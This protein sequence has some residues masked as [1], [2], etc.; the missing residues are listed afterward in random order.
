MIDKK[1]P[2]IKLAVLGHPIKH[3]LSPQIHQYFAKQHARSIDYQKIDID[4]ELAFNEF[5]QQASHEFIGCNVTIPYKQSLLTYAKQN[6][7]TCTVS[8]IAYQAKAANTIAF[9]QPKPNQHSITNTDGQGFLNHLS[10]LG[11]DMTHQRI[12]II[13]AGGATMG[14]L[15]QLTHSFPSIR[16]RLYLCNRTI[17]K[18]H[19]LCLK[20]KIN[21]WQN[22]A[23]NIPFDII[24]NATAQGL[25]GNG[26]RNPFFSEHHTHEGT[27]FYDLFYDKTQLTPFLNYID[28]HYPTH[29]QADGLGM[30]IE[31]AALSYQLWFGE[32]PETKGLE[33]ILRCKKAL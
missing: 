17:K 32:M 5:L 26:Y 6:S 7:H 15:A 29:P 1:T 18:S 3:S 20:Y 19:D 33:T 25:Q 13:G 12:L 27:F 24:I 28:Q 14:L 30:L 21:H 23:E 9:H 10:Q 2:H 11:L 4:N 31:Q 22:C 16:Q 8:D